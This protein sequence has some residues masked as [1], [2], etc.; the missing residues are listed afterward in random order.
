MRQNI[1]ANLPLFALDNLHVRFHTF[2]RIRSSKK[3]AYVC[4]GVQAAELTGKVQSVQTLVDGL[5]STDRDKLPNEAE[6]T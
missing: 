1:A 6:F 4:I 2:L 3:I 5:L